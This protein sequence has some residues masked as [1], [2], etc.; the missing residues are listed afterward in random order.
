MSG[1]AKTG[2]SVDARN[3]QWK[4]REVVLYPLVRFG[5]VVWIE[6]F[7]QG[8]VLR[9]KGPIDLLLIDG[10]HAE[11][12]VERDWNDWSR[13]V[14]PAGVAIF[15]DARLFEGGWTT[16]EY[17]PVKLVNRLFT[18]GTHPEWSIVEETHSLFMLQRN[19]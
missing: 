8:A 4:K 15:H 6:K 11:A 2:K 3:A 10:D 14:K 9:W 1:R 5:K 7:S 16:P 18:K 13:F 19:A 12:A 17:G